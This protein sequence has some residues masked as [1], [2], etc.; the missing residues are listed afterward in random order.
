MDM[1][2]GAEPIRSWEAPGLG[3]LCTHRHGVLGILEEMEYHSTTT[4]IP[5]SS[6]TWEIRGLPFLC[7][8]AFSSGFSSSAILP[9]ESRRFLLSLGNIWTL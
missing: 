6:V 9:A 4:F 1:A 3:E 8:A 2:R 5:S 7:E